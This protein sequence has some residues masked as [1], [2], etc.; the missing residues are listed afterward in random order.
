MN[1]LVVETPAEAATLEH[2]AAIVLGPLER[3]LDEAGLGSG[4]LDVRELG[5]GHSNLTFLLRRGEKTMVLRRPPR[6]D[7]AAS[8][9]NVVRESRILEAVGRSGVPVPAVIGRCE[10][11]AII[12]A[13]FSLMAFVDGTLVSD[14]IPPNLD[15][16]GAPE[17]IAGETVD[18]LA[19]LHAVDVVQTGLASFGKPTG[20]LERQLRIFNSLAERYSTRPLPDLNRTAVWLAANLP[21]RRESAFVHGDYRLGNLMYSEPLHLSAVLDWEMATLGDPLADLG[22]LTAMWA[23][24]DDDENPMFSLSRATTSG[25][26]PSRDDLVRR[27]AETS[28]RRVDELGWY[29]VLALWKSAIVLEG[30]YLRFA[31]GASTDPFFESL[32]DG[33]PAIGAAA[34]RWIASLRS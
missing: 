34:V 31:S 29:Q 6:G 7:L 2:G 5:D 26:F 21:R 23:A 20:Y 8:A 18:A 11:P 33:V 14:R 32:A 10:D 4:P 27:Y 3:F 13:P 16:P 19:A 24:P 22:Y 12:G 17:R 30:S 9:N 1:D 25:G 15:L 28:G